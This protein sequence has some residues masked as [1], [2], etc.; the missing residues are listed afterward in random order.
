M[1]NT[2]PCGLDDSRIRFEPDAEEDD[3]D[4]RT[5]MEKRLEWLFDDWADAHANNTFDEWHSVSMAIHGAFQAL[6]WCHQEDRHEDRATLMML[7]D[8]AFQNSLACISEDR[9]EGATK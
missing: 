2:M 8:V 5:P 1:Q 9:Y 3:N 7:G 4:P 6:I